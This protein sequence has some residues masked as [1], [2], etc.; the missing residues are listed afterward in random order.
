LSLPGDL[1]LAAPDFF[2]ASGMNVSYSSRL[3]NAEFN[4]LRNSGSSSL[5]WLYGFRYLGLN[6]HLDI[7]SLGAIG[8]GNYAIMTRNNMFGIQGGARWVFNYRCLY[9][10][11]TAK[12]G[13]L[14][15]ATQ[16]TQN[17]TDSAFPLA[18]RNTLEKGANVSFLGEAGGNAVYKLSEHWAIR[19]GYTL[20]WVNGLA[21][22]PNQLD[23]TF[24][25]SSG[26]GLNH[27]GNLLLQAINL[28]AE[29]HW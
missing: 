25:A 13:V 23:Y 5:S 18:L 28:G 12:G 27:G 26:T 21:L 17:V 2:D 10:E 16:Q 20:I 11:A 4:V 1:G 19:T 6:E 14:E 29:L 24:N 7:N 9:L 3:N 8:T 15:N 22:A